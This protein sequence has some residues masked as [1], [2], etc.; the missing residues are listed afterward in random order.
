MVIKTTSLSILFWL[1]SVAF[2][3]TYTAPA[4]AYGDY[5]D[6]DYDDYAEE[7]SGDEYTSQI[8]DPLESI[9]RPIAGFNDLV[10]EPILTVIDWYGEIVPSNVRK[11]IRNSLRNVYEP[12]YAAN[13]VIEGDLDGTIASVARL[14]IN[15]LAGFGGTIDVA[16]NNCLPYTP[17]GLS[18]TLGVYGVPPG[19]YIV[20]PFIGPSTLRSSAGL[21]VETYA[22]VV[23]YLDQALFG[24]RDQRYQNIVYFSYMGLRVVDNLD[25]SKDAIRAGREAALDFYS[26]SRAA[27]YQIEG[28]RIKNA[29]YPDIWTTD[30]NCDVTARKNRRDD[31]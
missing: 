8:W 2:C 26:F 17:Q 16:G 23:P 27:F 9:N 5:A 13:N 7:E 28:N 14:A 30:P 1:L 4:W 29:R 24:G 20:L 21:A 15:T 6:S 10:I 31:F 3:I 12:Y 18:T 22:D 19:P 11:G 25:S